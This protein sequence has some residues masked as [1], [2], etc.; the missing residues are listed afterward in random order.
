[1][2]DKE[3]IGPG[4]QQG[5]RPA[6][7]LVALLAQPDFTIPDRGVPD[8]WRCKVGSYKENGHPAEKPV[9]L[10]RRIIDTAAVPDN[11][12]VLD[13]FMGSG[14]AAVAACTT[15]RRFIGIEAEERWC[16][17]AVRRLAQTSLFGVGAIE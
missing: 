15:G 4:G 1:V 9:S 3:W 2:W 10:V 5:L 11:E 8:V 13:P 7:E 6:Y 14:T 12:V 16:E 17:M